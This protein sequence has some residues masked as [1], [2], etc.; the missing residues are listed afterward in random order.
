MSTPYHSQANRQVEVTNR[1]LETI[2]TKTVQRHHKDWADRL[3]EALWAYRTTWRAS[4][5]HHENR[6]LKKWSTEVKWKINA[7]A[8][9]T[10]SKEICKK[11]LQV[12]HVSPTIHRSM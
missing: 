5:P 4:S 9:V 1:V 3:P 8:H 2:L 6:W 7:Q 11:T 12:A 10:N